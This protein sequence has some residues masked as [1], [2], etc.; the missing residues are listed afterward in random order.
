MSAVCRWVACIVLYF[1]T[2]WRFSKR[3]KQNR[4]LV[5]RT[6]QELE[7]LKKIMLSLVA[8]HTRVSVSHHLCDQRNLLK[9]QGGKHNQRKKKEKVRGCFHM[10]ITCLL[11]SSRGVQAS[12][13]TGWRCCTILLQSHCDSWCVKLQPVIC[14]WAS[15]T[16][17]I[18]FMSTD[19]TLASWPSVS[20][21]SFSR[22]S[23]TLQPVSNFTLAWQTYFGNDS[24][25]P[26]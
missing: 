7:P 14:D 20:L 10:T 5:F 8:K 3:T 19:W 15:F 1:C 12:L 4:W 11:P 23:V 6:E 18:I 26:L 21:L 9:K 24:F 13:T 22:D 16:F 17:V 25:G 2:W